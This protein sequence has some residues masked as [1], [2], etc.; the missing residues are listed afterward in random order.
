MIE[1]SILVDLMRSLVHHFQ[2]WTNLIMSLLV[3]Q[4]FEME[5]A[6]PR[7]NARTLLW[8]RIRQNE[9]ELDIRGQSL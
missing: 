3:V 7:S 9:Q 5:S 2:S 6:Y 8:L 4:N 1:D